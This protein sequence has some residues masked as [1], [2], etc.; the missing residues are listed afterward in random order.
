[1]PIVQKAAEV[2]CSQ[3]Q[4][5][6]LVNDISA[7]P[8]FIS[9]CEATEIKQ[10]SDDELVASVAISAMGYSKTFTTHNLLQRPKMM[11]MKLLDGPFKHLTGFWQFKA[12]GE[13][14]ARVSLYLEFEF[15][16]PLLSRLVTPILNKMA[17]KLV[18]VFVERAHAIYS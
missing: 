1:M 9:W 13:Q 12:L 15:I 6:D 16:D 4:I 3:S 8:A 2:Q 10:Q 18:D 7:Y 17:N 11:E 14:E 5:F